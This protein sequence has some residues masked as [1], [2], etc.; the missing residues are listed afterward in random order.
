MDGVV[1]IQPHVAMSCQMWAW[2]SLRCMHHVYS[3]C[4]TVCM[5]LCAVSKVPQVRGSG[6]CWG[7]GSVHPS[8]AAGHKDRE[9]ERKREM[10]RLLAVHAAWGGWLNTTAGVTNWSSLA[11][12]WIFSISLFFFLIFTSHILHIFNFLP[13]YVSPCHLKSPTYLCL[14]VVYWLLLIHF[15]HPMSILILHGSYL[16]LGSSTGESP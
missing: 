5:C 4:M 15:F 13:S 1:N 12:N 14:S 7:H 6:G 11:D 16:F 2:E 9:E 3:M 10:S 8:A